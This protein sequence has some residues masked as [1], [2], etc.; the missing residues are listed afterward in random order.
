MGSGSPGGKAVV[1]N[2]TPFLYGASRKTLHKLMKE[3][4]FCSGQLPVK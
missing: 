1:K 4:R 3:G 2:F